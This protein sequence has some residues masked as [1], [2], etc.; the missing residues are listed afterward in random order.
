MKI[1]LKCQECGTDLTEDNIGRIENKPDKKIVLC[2]ECYHETE[3]YQ[4]WKRETTK[5]VWRRC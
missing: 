3:R 4:K 1:D 2:K 5:K